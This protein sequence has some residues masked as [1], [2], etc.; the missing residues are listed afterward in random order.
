MSICHL[1]IYPSIP[2]LSIIYLHCLYKW[3]ST[4]LFIYP[5]IYVYPLFCLPFHCHRQLT[6][7]SILAH[8]LPSCFLLHWEKGGLQK[9][10]F[11]ISH[12]HNSPLPCS[13]SP[14]L[15]SLQRSTAQGLCVLLAKASLTL[16]ALDLTY[17]L[18]KEA[19]PAM[20]PSL[21]HHQ[22]P[23]FWN[24]L[25]SMQKHSLTAIPSPQLSCPISSI[26]PSCLLSPLLC[27]NLVSTAPPTSLCLLTLGCPGLSFFYLC[28]LS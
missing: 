17:Y 5:P 20:L 23:S 18:F 13:V 11:I 27:P 15:S 8:S 2:H 3:I 22:F 21:L 9:A 12:H 1:S 10:N 6:P 4:Y 16:C 19:M 7:K 24:L 28:S 26:W 25:H 14:A